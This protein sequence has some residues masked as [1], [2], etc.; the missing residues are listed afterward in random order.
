L[1]PLDALGSRL[2]DAIVAITVVASATT[3]GVAACRHPVRRLALTRLALLAVLITIPVILFV[4]AQ[5]DRPALESIVRSSLGPLGATADRVI[6]WLPRAALVLATISLTASLASALLS[7][8]AVRRLLARSRAP[9]RTTFLVYQEL[10]RPDPNPPLRVSDRVKHPLVVGLLRPTIVIPASLEGD[11]SPALRFALAHEL[12]HVR[13]HDSRWE[14][15]AAWIQGLGFLLPPLGWLRAQMR[16]DQEYV[17]DELV[18]ASLKS[19]GDYAER[20]VAAV[21]SGGRDRGSPPAQ[22]I[23]AWPSARFRPL[24]ARVALLLQ[25]QGRFQTRAPWTWVT[26]T[27]TAFGALILALSQYTV[28]TATWHTEQ[29]RASTL[30][31]PPGELRVAS[32]VISQRDH[33]AP[34]PACVPILGNLPSSLDMSFSIPLGSLRKRHARLFGVTLWL[35]PGFDDSVSESE[36]IPVRIERDSGTLFVTIG[37]IRTAAPIPPNASPGTFIAEA[38]EPQLVTLQNILIRWPHDGC[39]NDGAPEPAT[40]LRLAQ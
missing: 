10:T 9:D 40:T 7:L 33:T 8:W 31:Q 37:T 12:T 28:L 35:P 11:V 22:P 19:R 6:V 21:P 20:L 16:I 29:S 3:L 1:S 2:L 38:V 39:Q 17:A 34:A 25:P 4:P 24:A 18:A 5:S 30:N 23:R 26:L 36:L 14:F 15:L 32:L 13:R 27:A